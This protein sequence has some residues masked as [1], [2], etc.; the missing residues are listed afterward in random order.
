ML[1]RARIVVGSVTLLFASVI[2]VGGCVGNPFA[3]AK[4]PLTPEAY[5]AA[6]F[7]PTG[8]GNFFYCGTNQANLAVVAFP[9]GS[10][11]YCM[12]ADTNNLGLVGYSAYTYSG[13]AFPVESQ[14]DASAH[15]S[16]LGSQ[17]AGYI[18][19]TRQ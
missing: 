1:K 8:Y 14:S 12:S 11:G 6:E 10:H 13:G 7:N 16:L 18:R 15:C 5:C 19:C 9:D 17:C 3:P 4:P 2:M